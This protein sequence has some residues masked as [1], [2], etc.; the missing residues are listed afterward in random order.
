MAVAAEWVAH[1]KAHRQQQEIIISLTTQVEQQL[2][3]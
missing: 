2:L 3:A 1:R